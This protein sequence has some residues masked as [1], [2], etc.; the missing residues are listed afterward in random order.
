MNGIYN[1]GK[2]I[3]YSVFILIVSCQAKTRE[4]NVQTITVEDSIIHNMSFVFVPKGE[5]TLGIKK[6]VKMLPYDYWIMK[7]EV[8]NKQYFEFL[9]SALN[10]SILYRDG[11]SI[12]F[13]YNGDKLRKEGN[14]VVKILDDRIYFHI[15]QL[16]L[17]STYWNH[18]VTEITWFGAT[19]FCNY[20]GF[21]VP[22]KFE[23]EK[24]ARGMTGWNYPWGD[25][26]ESIRA[27]YHNSGDPFD[28]GTTPVGF[29][30]GQNYQGYQTKDSPSPYG[31]Y[32]MAGNAWEYTNSSILPDMP[33]VQGAG[34]G[35][36][37]HTGAMC[38]SWYFSLFGYP[39]PAKIDR[40]FKSDGFRCVIKY[41]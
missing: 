40:P 37:Y 16:M 7:Y 38:Q 27:N 22:D 14:Y 10:D 36:L 15:N 34:G 39:V 23:W 31:C 9:T 5:Y 21:S 35:F 2:Y 29:Y 3:F 18:P 12:K 13:H 8:T 25:T 11:D 26:L 17:D 6:K 41:Y 33:F 4:S 20:Y 24:A 30:N 28:N 1:F 19:A 32:D